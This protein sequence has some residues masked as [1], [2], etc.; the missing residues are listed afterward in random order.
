MGEASARPSAVSPAKS[1][2]VAFTFAN[3][4]S[5]Q[6]NEEGEGKGR[7]FKKKNENFGIF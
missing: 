7:S 6:Q 1:P 4:G 2:F 3:T 5:R